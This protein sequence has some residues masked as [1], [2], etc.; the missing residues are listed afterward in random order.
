[1]ETLSLESGVRRG[2]FGGGWVPSGPQNRHIKYFEESAAMSWNCGDPWPYT[3][4]F[5][6]DPPYA[7]YLQAPQRCYR[8]V[9]T[10]GARPIEE[11]S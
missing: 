3:M 4:P 9:Q 1:V 7:T 2:C 10:E 6:V 11:A 8:V 5:L